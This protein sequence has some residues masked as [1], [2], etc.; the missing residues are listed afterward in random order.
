MVNEINEAQTKLLFG[1]ANYGI[2]VFA[3]IGPTETDSMEA[4]ATLQQQWDDVSGLIE[5]GLIDDASEKFPE[6]IENIKV[7]QPGR[8][9]RICMITDMA[10]KMFEN[11]D[12]RAVN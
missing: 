6:N 7:Q 12:G 8:K 11:G 3:S 4:K 5:M 2:K 1:A 10:Q 9:A